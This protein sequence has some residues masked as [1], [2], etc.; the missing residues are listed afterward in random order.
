MAG[1]TSAGHL[2]RR[3]LRKKKASPAEPNSLH[4]PWWRANA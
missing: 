3:R 1:V 2:H 4:A